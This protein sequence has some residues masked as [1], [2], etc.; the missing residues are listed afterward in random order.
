MVKINFVWFIL[1][2]FVF[3]CFMYELFIFYIIFFVVE[4]FVF[5]NYWVDL[6]GYFLN[7]LFLVL[8]VLR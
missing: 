1:N 7:S 8:Y 2:N 3:I 4:S 5:W 6:V